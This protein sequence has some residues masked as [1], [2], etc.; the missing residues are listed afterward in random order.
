M[1]LLPHELV[2]LPLD[3]KWQSFLAFHLRG[4]LKQPF[5][6]YQHSSLLL[7]F[8][9]SYYQY[10]KQRSVSAM[11][12]SVGK[13]RPLKCRLR[14]ARSKL[15]ALRQRGKGK[16]DNSTQIPTTLAAAPSRETVAAAQS[17]RPSRATSNIW[18]PYYHGGTSSLEV[19][20]PCSGP[21]PSMPVGM[22][23]LSTIPR[24]LN[25]P[26]EIIRE[27]CR[28]LDSDG[29]R[30]ARTAVPNLRITCKA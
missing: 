20:T 28:I 29:S 25:L 9:E 6:P 13:A 18:R 27:I 15:L 1:S 21:A 10:S 14:A 8:L 7:S 22:P 19:H 23:D 17:F 11:P 4:P 3:V 5:T 12:N 30:V 16:D 26:S 2:C 24:P